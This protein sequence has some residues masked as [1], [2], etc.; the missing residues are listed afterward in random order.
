MDKRFYT[1][2]QV[3][4][5]ALQQPLPPMRLYPPRVQQTPT[6]QPQ[7]ASVQQAVPI[8]SQH[9][10][11]GGV[12]DRVRDITRNYIPLIISSINIPLFVRS[13][14][15]NIIQLLSKINPLL[16]LISPFLRFIVSLLFSFLVIFYFPEIMAI[17]DLLM[18]HCAKYIE[19]V[20]IFLI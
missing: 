20:A 14:G 11:R 15:T 19:W 3:K 13:V 4:Q 16:C 18:E 7:Q 10:T 8:Q 5:A 1:Y 6:V 12:Y 2:A 17:Y 9:P